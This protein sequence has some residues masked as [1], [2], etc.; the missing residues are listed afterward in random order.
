MELKEILCTELIISDVKI[1]YNL[2]LKSCSNLC[3]IKVRELFAYDSEEIIIRDNKLIKIILDFVND[4]SDNRNRNKE[5]SS[6]KYPIIIIKQLTN[7]DYVIS[8]GVKRWKTK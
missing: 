7:G 3:I 4:F 8:D 5:D 6:I 2:G 1:M